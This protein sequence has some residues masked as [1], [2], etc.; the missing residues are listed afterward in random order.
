MAQCYPQITGRIRRF[1]EA[2]H[3][4][5]VAT[6]AR[7]GRVNVSP[8]GLDT[9][10]ILDPNRVAWLNLTGSGNETAAHVL[11]TPRMTF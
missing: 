3:M 4:F 10:R 7:S 5:F 8:K 1:I 11:D 9:L 2:Q 6:A